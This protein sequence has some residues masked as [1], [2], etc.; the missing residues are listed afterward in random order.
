MGLV[1]RNTPRW[2]RDLALTACC[3]A[4]VA[5]ADR[6]G[7][8][9]QRAARLIDCL[10]VLRSAH[11]AGVAA[12]LDMGVLRRGLR[13]GLAPLL[14]AGS[15]D[16]PLGE[17]RL[18]DEDGAGPNTAAQRRSGLKIGEDPRQERPWSGQSSAGPRQRPETDLSATTSAD[19]SLSSAVLALTEDGLERPLQQ[20]LAHAALAEPLHALQAPF[21]SEAPNRAY[22][23]AAYA[24]AL[25]MT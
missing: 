3:A 5:E 9:G 11:D 21:A 24:S 18:L 19:A 23:P 20:R 7:D 4:A 13:R 1:E 22:G 8:P 6:T 2:R 14:P 17:M 15:D 25:P 16:D 12:A 10:G